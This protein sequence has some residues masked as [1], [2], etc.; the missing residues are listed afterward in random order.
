MQNVHKGVI[1]SLLSN[2][3][4]ITLPLDS[5][6]ATTISHDGSLIASSARDH[7]LKVF[8]TKDMKMI[9]Y[10][11]EYTRGIF[12]AFRPGDSLLTIRSYK[13]FDIYKE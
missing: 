7:S 10:K 9:I 2:N 1:R 6:Y 11:E 4:P 12:T 8:T 3:Y 13:L 5:I